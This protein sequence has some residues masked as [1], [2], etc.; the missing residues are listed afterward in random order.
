MFFYF[1]PAP[2]AVNDI[3][4]YNLFLN[5]GLGYMVPCMYQ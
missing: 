5:D 1:L 4:L 3:E 2:Y